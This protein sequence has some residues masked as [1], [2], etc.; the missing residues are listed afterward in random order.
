M[1]RSAVQSCTNDSRRSPSSSDTLS[2]V[3]RSASGSFSSTR[4]RQV[5]SSSAAVIS[6]VSDLNAMSFVRSPR[7]REVQLARRVTGGGSHGV[8]CL[9]DDRL[10]DS[11]LDHDVLHPGRVLSPHA[12]F[13]CT[14]PRR[15]G[16]LGST[17][18]FV[19]LVV[20]VEVTVH[21]NRPEGLPVDLSSASTAGQ[22]RAGARC[23]RG[24]KGCS[25]AGPRRAVP[26]V[27]G[28]WGG[29]A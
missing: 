5:S 2:S 12:G 3:C 24:V 17:F 6:G 19:W 1:S 23:P 4:C 8:D 27:A 10:R 16:L 26:S 28:E 9:V 25:S 21:G 13:V 7:G 14:N 18:C 22:I 15:S 11:D 20:A 29:V